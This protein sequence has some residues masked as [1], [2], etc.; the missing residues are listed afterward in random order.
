MLNTLA[1]ESGH[2]LQA[3]IW[4]CAERQI[5]DLD[6]KRCPFWRQGCEFT[7]AAIGKSGSIFA[8]KIETVQKCWIENELQL[9]L[10][11]I[12]NVHLQPQ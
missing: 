3:S 7:V 4:A 8:D 10:R 12:I 5:M 11:H 9:N 1:A 2:G 6:A